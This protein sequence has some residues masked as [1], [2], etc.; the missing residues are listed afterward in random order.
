MFWD[1]L[2]EANLLGKKK[3]QVNKDYKTGCFFYSLFLATK[4]K[5]RLTINGLGKKFGNG[6]T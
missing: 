5:Y 2:D 6:K 3:F 4:M 1:V